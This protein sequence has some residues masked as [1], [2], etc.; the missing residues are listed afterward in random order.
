MGCCEISYSPSL[1]S[2]GALE[3]AGQ[4]IPTPALPVPTFPD[5]W[6][7]VE[8]GCAPEGYSPRLPNG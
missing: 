8:R 5:P 7:S 3:R 6:D 2:V 4:R 1:P